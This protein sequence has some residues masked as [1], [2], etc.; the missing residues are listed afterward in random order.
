[1]KEDKTEIKFQNKLIKSDKERRKEEENMKGNK[2][3]IRTKIKKTKR[4]KYRRRK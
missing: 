4:K 1:M 2:R 3:K